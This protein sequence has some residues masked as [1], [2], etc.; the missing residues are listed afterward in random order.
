MELLFVKSQNQHFAHPSLSCMSPL[1][2]PSKLRPQTLLS[3]FRFYSAPVSLQLSET[4]KAPNGRKSSS[5]SSRSNSKARVKVS[6]V[7]LKDNWLSSLTCPFP[8]RLESPGGE[9][10]SP[11]KSDGSDWVIGIDP[12][13]SGALAVLRTDQLDC[14]A[15][16]FDSPH[17]Q[18]L[19]GKRV[20]RRLD[21]KSIVQLITS[22]GAPM[23]TVAY[24]EQSTPF[25]QDGKLGWWSGGFGY[26]LWIG[27]LVAS[28]FSVV[29]VPSSLWKNRFEL[30]GSRYNKDSSRN[31]ASEMFPSV[32]PMLKRKK[33]HGRAEALLIAAYGK[34]CSVKPDE[35]TAN[36]I[37]KVMKPN[38][39]P[40]SYLPL[41]H[42]AYKFDG[43]VTI[44]TNPQILG[45]KNR[46]PR[47]Q[48]DYCKCNGQLLTVIE[49]N[50]FFLFLFNVMQYKTRNGSI[51]QPACLEY[52]L[53]QLLIY[54]C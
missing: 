35:A 41:F 1:S 38:R 6:D 46:H 25:P 53:L 26:G 30:S 16:V 11:P 31:L 19:V 20:R 43:F 50:V 27:T 21:P 42:E 12:D 54:L 15:Q 2:L 14:S 47:A 51:T 7:Q 3:R 5:S 13:V 49:K 29:P 23:G 36:A 8:A 34:R 44:P 52:Q 28:G 18:M 17:V 10:E 48:A 22:L 9:A 32:S 33:D 37:S 45:H 39:V 24:I 4:I 40:H